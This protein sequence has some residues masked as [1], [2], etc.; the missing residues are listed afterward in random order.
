MRPP[1]E[2]QATKIGA[3]GEF[4]GVFPDAAPWPASRRL[5]LRSGKLAREIDAAVPRHQVLD[6]VEVAAEHAVVGALEAVA[7]RGRGH[8]ATIALA[9]PSTAPVAMYWTL[10]RPSLAVM[11]RSTAFDVER[12]IFRLGLLLRDDVAL[13]EV[14]A[15]DIVDLDVVAAIGGLDHA[16]IVEEIVLVRRQ[17]IGGQ[18]RRDGEDECRS[19]GG[20]EI[21]ASL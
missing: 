21:R 17:P 16:G 9:P 11:S 2:P 5:R 14:A 10:T 20:E 3:P 8:R 6:A 12:D 18:S 15:L 1:S 7:A 4:F 13:V 19:R